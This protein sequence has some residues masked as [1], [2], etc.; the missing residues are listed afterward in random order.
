MITPENFKPT[1]PP[2]LIDRLKNIPPQ[3]QL[4]IGFLIIGI[5]LVLAVM[6]LYARPSNGEDT[7]QQDTDISTADTSASETEE[8]IS[9][10]T[11]TTIDE[12]IAD[13]DTDSVSEHNFADSFDG[14]VPCVKFGDSPQAFDLTF[15]VQEA[16]DILVQDCSV[17]VLNTGY[18]LTF[19]FSS[20]G[21]G[22]MIDD[23][24]DMPKDVSAVTAPN[25][26]VKFQSDSDQKIKR[27]LH[28][29]KE[30]SYEYTSYFAEGADSCSHWDSTTPPLACGGLP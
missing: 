22:Y 10:A 1:K 7:S 19:S 26:D 15:S 28:A 24:E 6:Y 13:P 20:D 11:P 27:L 8:D 30:N 5:Q 23:Q 16:S 29:K 25:L 12:S 4:I 17:I 18:Q 21:A 14:E 9:E 2:S 3:T